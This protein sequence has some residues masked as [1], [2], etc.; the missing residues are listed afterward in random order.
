MV[1]HASAMSILD[2]TTGVVECLAE[3][4]E[5]LTLWDDRLVAIIHMKLEGSYFFTLCVNHVR[6]GTKVKLPTKPASKLNFKKKVVSR[7]AAVAVRYNDEVS[8]KLG[9]PNLKNFGVIIAGDF[10]LTRHEVSDA[11]SAIERPRSGSDSVQFI[12]GQ[13]FPDDEDGCVGR[14]RCTL[15]IVCA[16]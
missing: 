6:A 5:H 12:G 16:W 2:D 8:S 15:V 13:L 7:A 11:A 14:G 10:N 3:P 1:R 9:V 4:S